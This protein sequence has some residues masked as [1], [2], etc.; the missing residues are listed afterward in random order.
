MIHGDQDEY[1]TTTV[2]RSLFQTAAEPKHYDE[3]AGADHRFDGHR[4]EFYRSLK[5]GLEW[6]V[7]Q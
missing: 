4:D 3:V 5:R 2:A 6:I 7:A 1:T